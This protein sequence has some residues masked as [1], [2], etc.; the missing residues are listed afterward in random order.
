MK[1]WFTIFCALWGTISHAQDLPAVYNV[2]NVA[3][4]DVLNIRRAP[5]AGAEIMGSYPPYSINIEVLEISPD[6]KW[7]MVGLGEGNGWVNLSYLEP[8][9][10]YSEYEVPMPL[11]CSGT[12]P[13][14]TFGIYPGGSE[15]IEMG[16]ERR[17]LEITAMRRAANGMLITAQEGEVIDRTLI[18]QRGECSDGMSDRRFGWRATLFNDTPDMPSVET[19][20]C[21]LD[22][23]N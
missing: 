20:C 21:T 12:E 23:T 13:F 22:G 16:D 5:D 14:W 10:T 15:Y 11:V 6:G 8:S 9:T 7:G 19:G 1:Y 3:A 17:D 18:V 4:N 2:N